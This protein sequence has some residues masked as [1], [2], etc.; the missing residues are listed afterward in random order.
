MKTTTRK[1]KHEMPAGMRNARRGRNMENLKGKHLSFEKQLKIGT[2]ITTTLPALK[3]LCT[4]P[5]CTPV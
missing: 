2:D 4:V 3:Y 1:W 5:K